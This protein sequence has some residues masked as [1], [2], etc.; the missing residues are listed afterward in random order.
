MQFKAFIEIPDEDIRRRHMKYDKSG[1]IDLGLI[2]DKIPVN[3]G[4]CIGNY[5]YLINTANEEK[6]DDLDAIIFSS[7]VFKPGD[8]LD[9]VPFAMLIRKDLDHKVLASDSNDK[10]Q[11]QTWNDIPKDL[12]KLIYDFYGFSSLIEKVASADETLK[13][14]EKCQKLFQDQSKL[15][16]NP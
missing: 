10:T 1:L 7:Q 16:K 3:D 15:Q 4:R 2:K 14:I 11:Y 13:Y 5:G 6:G 9:V 8:K 12:Q